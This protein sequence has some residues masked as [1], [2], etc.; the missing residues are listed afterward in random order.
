MNEEV[1]FERKSSY[2][3]C[4]NCPTFTDL[5]QILTDIY[6]GVRFRIRVSDYTLVRLSLGRDRISSLDHF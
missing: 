2:S 3:L 5:S 6:T 1:E 4:S